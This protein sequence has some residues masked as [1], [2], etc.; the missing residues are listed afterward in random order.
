MRKTATLTYPADPARVAAMLANT[1]YQHERVARLA[2]EDASVDVEARGQGFV[3]TFSGLVPPSRLPAAASRFVRSA[4]RV[5]VTE[6][7]G[8]PAADGAR[9]GSL[10]IAVK[11]APVRAGA[12]TSLRPE[13]ET[14]RV[15]LDLD[16]RV[17]VPLVGPSLEERA[18]GMLGQALADE[19]RRA[20]A[21]LAGH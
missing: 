1:G 17:H 15:D 19:E 9:S 14:T 10:E 20:T 2:L 5:L 18:L 13:G 6:S 8:E 16:L 21:W 7:W 4:V 3:V 12:T 11:G